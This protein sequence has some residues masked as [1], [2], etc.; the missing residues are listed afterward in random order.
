[1]N[2][3]EI[4]YQKILFGGQLD[5]LVPELKRHQSRIDRFFA[6]HNFES[7]LN[8][9]QE[10]LTSIQTGESVL[11]KRFANLAK[12]EKLSYLNS[13]ITEMAE[14]TETPFLS[15][16]KIR[17]ILTTH[18]PKILK[19]HLSINPELNSLSPRGQLSLTRFS[20]NYDWQRKYHKILARTT[21]SDYEARLPECINID[22]NSFSELT[23]HSGQAIKPWGVS[24]SKETGIIIIFENFS[25][26]ILTPNFLMFSVFLHYIFEVH[27][28]SSFI[29]ENS[30]LKTGQVVKNI[31]RNREPMLPFITDGNAHDETLYWRKAIK[32]IP[33]YTN[34]NDKILGACT[35]SC[36]IKEGFVRSLNII[37]ILWN[38]NNIYPESNTIYHLQQ[39]IWYCLLKYI[40]ST[41]HFEDTVKESLMLD[42]VSFLNKV[43]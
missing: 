18:P 22:A 39:E 19:K 27:H 2:M 40:D 3:A 37:D 29:Q 30:H 9:I 17:E 10:I 16:C 20:E 13:I 24:H 8:T 32:K 23:R 36:T 1:M 28:F 41:G 34:L 21:F 6:D 26:Q 12:G 5:K 4:S 25:P 38:I 35:Q 31:L 7:P 11:E 42:N 43:L 14:V 15:D 33:D